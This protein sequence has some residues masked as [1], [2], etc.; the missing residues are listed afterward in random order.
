ML[1][2]L[3]EGLFGLL[4]NNSSAELHHFVQPS[5]YLLVCHIPHFAVDSNP[6]FEPFR[7]K[8]ILFRYKPFVLEAWSGRKDVG[9]VAAISEY[10][11]ELKILK[12]SRIHAQAKDCSAFETLCTALS[13]Q[14]F[15]LR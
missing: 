14:A 11:R 4:W 2:I 10:P 12:R 8:K 1:L 3:L 6:H 15:Q 13:Y 7:S 5:Y 9:V